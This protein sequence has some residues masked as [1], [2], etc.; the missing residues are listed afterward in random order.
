MLKP[1]KANPITEMNRQIIFFF[2]LKR[3]LSL[4]FQSSETSTFMIIMCIVFHFPF[5]YM[6]CSIRCLQYRG[7]HES[8]YPYIHSKETLQTSER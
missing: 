5:P 2:S 3:M 1:D 6:Y 7:Y 4:A 8:T